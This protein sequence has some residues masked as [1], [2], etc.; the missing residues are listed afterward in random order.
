ML[1]GNSIRQFRLYLALDVRSFRFIAL[2]IAMAFPMLPATIAGQERDTSVTIEAGAYAGTVVTLAKGSATR[3]A[4]HIWRLA[5]RRD[6]RIVGWNPTHFPIA[7]AFR[8]G[9]GITAD[10]SIAFWRNIGQMEDDIGIAIFTPATLGTDDDPDDVIVVGTRSISSS[11]DGVT[12][13]TWN[14]S[15]VIYDARVYLKTPAKVHDLGTVTHEMMHALGF[16]HTNDLGSIMNASPIVS[17][18]SPRDVAYVQ[19]ALQS[20]SESEMAD[21]WERLALSVERGTLPMS[22]H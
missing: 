4:S 15:G 2:C 17:R 10:D 19:L 8:P 5:S 12:Y 14:S 20:R 16:G 3:G 11:A 18:L 7:V 1:P 21:I 13:V 22:R 6:S 9:S